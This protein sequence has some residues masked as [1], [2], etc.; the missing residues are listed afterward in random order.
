MRFARLLGVLGALLLVGALF[1]SG[2]WRSRPGRVVDGARQPADAAPLIEAG[3]PAE[4]AGAP[5]GPS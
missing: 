2:F 4:A 5:A 3:S 1:A